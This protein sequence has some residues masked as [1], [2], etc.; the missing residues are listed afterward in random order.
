MFSTLCLFRNKVQ[1]RN[2]YPHLCS[3]NKCNCTCNRKNR[4]FEY[5]SFKWIL[6]VYYAEVSSKRNQIVIYVLNRSHL[7]L[8]HNRFPN[9]TG[10]HRSIRWIHIAN[11]KFMWILRII[12]C[13]KIVHV[14]YLKGWA[15]LKSFNYS[16]KSTKKT[17]SDKLYLNIFQ[18][19]VFFWYSGVFDCGLWWPVYFA[20]GFDWTFGFDLR[21]NVLWNFV[22][23]CPVSVGHLKVGLTFQT[24]LPQRASHS[25]S[26]LVVKEY[27]QV[28]PIP[29]L[30]LSVYL[31]AQDLSISRKRKQTFDVER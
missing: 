10:I 3:C 1:E 28:L 9:Q 12:F 20:R 16:I 2:W 14:V 31:L 21:E 25:L 8:R 30:V 18:V 26:L 22:V 27:L 4:Q 11:T 24:K 5:A 17:L 13:L 7:C 19:F 29:G 23:V 6:P 15:Q